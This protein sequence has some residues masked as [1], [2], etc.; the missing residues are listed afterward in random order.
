MAQRFFVPVFLPPHQLIVL[1]TL[2]VPYSSAQDYALSASFET[3]PRPIGARTCLT[4]PTGLPRRGPHSWVYV[5]VCRGPFP[6][7]L[8]SNGHDRTV[9]PPKT[10]SV[11]LSPSPTSTSRLLSRSSHSLMIKSILL[12]SA[13]PQHG[14]VHQPGEDA[15]P[16]AERARHAHRPVR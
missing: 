10:L 14:E 15:L 5:V 9:Q 4:M 11:P 1:S 8:F 13:G 16:Q 6:S 7:N 2:I 3:D 12:F